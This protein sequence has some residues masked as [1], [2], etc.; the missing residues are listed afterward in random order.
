[1]Q[2]WFRCELYAR[3]WS[4]TLNVALNL[5]RS[6][7]NHS[8]AQHS[9]WVVQYSSLIVHQNS[10]QTHVISMHNKWWI[11]YIHVFSAIRRYQTFGLLAA[12]GV[13]I[14]ITRLTT[15][16]TCKLTFR[17]ISTVWRKNQAFGVL[18][19]EV[20][21]GVAFVHERVDGD[22]GAVHVRQPSV[23]PA[24]CR[25]NNYLTV[26]DAVIAFWRENVILA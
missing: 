16:T 18:G 6:T 23:K 10:I 1:M 2:N 4:L 5:A 7:A 8:C 21:E 24:T 22:P 15:T 3:L 9:I 26:V 11:L 20:W 13:L 14:T 25:S 12:Q 17:Q 19:G